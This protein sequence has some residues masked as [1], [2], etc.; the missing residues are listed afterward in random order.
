MKTSNSNFAKDKPK[1]LKWFASESPLFV[2]LKIVPILLFLTYVIWTKITFSWFQ[3]LYIIIGFIFWSFSE[4]AIHRWIYHKK[5]K[6]EKIRWFVDAFH[7]HHH[8]D[9]QDY[10]V[11]NAGLF[12]IYPIFI[13]VFG[14]CLLL[15][16]WSF[17]VYFSLG[18]I[19]YYFFYENVHYF[20]HYKNYKKGYMHW[21]QKYHLYHH[22]NKWNKNYGNT[23]AIWDKIFGTY[24]EEFNHFKFDEKKKLDLIK[25][26]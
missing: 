24:D 5:Y 10:R 6:N 21:I 4:Y 8:K 23:L 18:V 7:I 3:I 17:S 2:L 26:S 13:I 16:S 14:S 11:L 1:L 15:T 25:K 22:Y 9:L 12:L 19:V 20:I